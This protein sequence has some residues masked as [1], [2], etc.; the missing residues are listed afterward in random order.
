MKEIAENK[1]LT[2]LEDLMSKK[3]G[4][5]GSKERE[6]FREEAR[7]FCLGKVIQEARKQEKV[8]LAELASRIGKDKSYIS[9]IENGVIDPSTGTFYKIIE[10]LGMKIEILK[11]II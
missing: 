1:N 9:K 4:A 7:A 3:Y 11:P 6:Q 10:A 5:V 8:T 2:N